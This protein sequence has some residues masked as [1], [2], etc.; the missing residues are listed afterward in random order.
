M[1][2]IVYRY[3]YAYE[4]VCVYVYSRK[5][6]QVRKKANIIVVVI[7]IIKRY[8]ISFPYIK[9]LLHTYIYSVILYYYNCYYYY[10]F[11]ENVKMLLS[12]HRFYFI[13]V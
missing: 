11:F 4:Y 6:L 5:L 13:A 3:I 10:F 1:L 8:V 7:K 12:M 9:M 2:I